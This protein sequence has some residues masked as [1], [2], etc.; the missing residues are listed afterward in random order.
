MNGLSDERRAWTLEAARALLSDV[1]SRTGRAVAEVERLEAARAETEPGSEE[2][3]RLEQEMRVT[4]SRWLR[5]MEALGLDVK[6]A[7]LVDFDNGRG[8]YCWRWPETGLDWF[9]DYDEGFGGRIR[10]Q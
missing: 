7:W 4:V 6:G 1:R 5:E 8:Y 2:H 9:H 10:I 3:L